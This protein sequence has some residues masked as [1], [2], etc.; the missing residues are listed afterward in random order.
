MSFETFFRSTHLPSLPHISSPILVLLVHLLLGLPNTCITRNYFLT[1][2]DAYF[3]RS[4]PTFRRYLPLLLSAFKMEAKVREILVLIYRG[5]LP[6]IP[7][8]HYIDTAVRLSKPTFSGAFIQYFCLYRPGHTSRPSYHY[9]SSTGTWP[10]INHE[11]P[12][13]ILS[14]LVSFVLLR[15]GCFLSIVAPALLTYILSTN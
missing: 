4:T 11:I 8:I 13:V 15:F 6:D 7:E 1:G 10:Y 12:C 9:L 3:D 5:T 14:L 2:F